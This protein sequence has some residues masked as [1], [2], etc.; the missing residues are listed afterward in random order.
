M[1]DLRAAW[2]DARREADNAERV[3]RKRKAFWLSTA[4]ERI[5]WPVKLLVVL[6]F[7]RS[8]HLPPAAAYF[9]IHS[10][11][12]ITKGLCPE[13]PPLTQ[14]DIESWMVPAFHDPAYLLAEADDPG[15]HM[16]YLASKHLAEHAA[17]E[18]LTLQCSRGVGVPSKELFSIYTQALPAPP[19]GS[20]LERHLLSL[21]VGK[22][23]GRE[24][25]LH[26]FRARWL[27]DYR[28]LKERPHRPQDLVGR[29]VLAGK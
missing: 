29:Q 18:W 28:H 22:P 6:I 19:P 8:G 24:K 15:S 7:C 9:D 2:L 21:G 3:V 12:R 27:V 1:A 14:E 23:K 25:W 4:R 10:R 16:A 11:T 13:T 20:K 5:S 17:W 26:A